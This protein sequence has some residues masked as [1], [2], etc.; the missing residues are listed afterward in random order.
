MKK[1]L[2]VLLLIGLGFSAN[3]NIRLGNFDKSPSAGG[4]IYNGYEFISMIVNDQ[5]APTASSLVWYADNI[6]GYSSILITGFEASTGNIPTTISAQAVY[7]DGTSV[8]VSAQTI[9]SGTALT[10]LYSPWYKFTLPAYSSTRNISF[11]FT[12]K[13]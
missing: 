9:T 1:I 6:M 10:T 7:P 8:S 3:A 12:V 11:M 2:V 4:Y 13:D 5:L